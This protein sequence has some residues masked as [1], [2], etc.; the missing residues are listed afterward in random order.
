VSGAN[1]DSVG[2]QF[3]WIYYC[4]WGVVLTSLPN[5]H[6][7]SWQEYLRVFFI[8]GAFIFFW[9]KFKNIDQDASEH[10]STLASLVALSM[11]FFTTQ[12]SGWNGNGVHWVGWLQYLSIGSGLVL[13]IRLV[14][15][16]GGGS[17]FS[18]L[19]WVIM[20]AGLVLTLLTVFVRFVFLSAFTVQITDIL[21]LVCVAIW[22]MAAN[23]GLAGRIGDEVSFKPV[24]AAGKKL[25]DLCTAALSLTVLVGLFQLAALWVTHQ[26]ATEYYRGGE[27][28]EALRVYS[29]VMEKNEV[30]AVSSFKEDALKKSASIRLRQGE[31]VQARELLGGLVSQDYRPE[32]H[33]QNAK[34]FFNFGFWQ[35]VIDEFKAYRNLEKKIGPDNI[36]YLFEAY[37]HNGYLMEAQEIA[38]A[39]NV[40]PEVMDVERDKAIFLADLQY[41]LGNLSM[42]EAAFKTLV[43][44]IPQAYLY[45]RLGTIAAAAGKTR[46]ARSYFE[47]SVAID[48]SFA[49]GWFRLANQLE[50][51]GLKKEALIRAIA[52]VPSHWASWNALQE[53]AKDGGTEERLQQLSPDTFFDYALRDE[54][55]LLGNDLPKTALRIGGSL[56]IALYWSVLRP[57]SRNYRTAFH[58]DL[59]DKE[60]GDIIRAI[61]KAADFSPAPAQRAIGEVVVQNYEFPVESIPANIIRNGQ[62]I[63]GEEM[64]T[65]RLKA[66][67]DYTLEVII[68]E[69]NLDK[70]E[71]VW[72]NVDGGTFV[73][74]D[75]CVEID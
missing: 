64:R 7:L 20:A 52:A 19:D 25:F 62:N 45:Y 2:R 9:R 12:F 11:M 34:L 47:Q 48:S 72:E 24:N 61:N 60:T 58:L 5:I 54:F 44:K 28:G 22:L 35:D 30:L 57:L 16:A 75:I 36:R 51:Q 23:K 63:D 55:H 68:Q 33:I 6:A 43:K 31:I 26:K 3:A 41:S 29:E 17:V 14:L 70:P 67:C 50:D 10:N 18:D 32:R 40:V 13:W 46:D 27:F 42:A 39:G 37:M 56:R 53:M 73:V 49:E 59:V 38:Q 71:S 21:P 1:K 65:Y 66:G 4:L 69:R 74:N 15:A 8:V